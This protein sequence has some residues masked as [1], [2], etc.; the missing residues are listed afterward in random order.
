VLFYPEKL[1]ADYKFTFENDFE[2]Y[3]IAVDSKTRISAL[4]FRAEISKG[5]VFYLHGNAG[6][7][8]SWGKLAEVYL[9][10]NYD[11]CVMDYR[12]FGKS[13]GEIENEKQLHNDVGI[14]YDTISSKYT[15]QNIVIIGY[16]IGTCPAARLASVNNP[17]LL[18]LQAP[19][20]SIPD[21]V[22]HMFWVVPP[23]LVKY[24]LRTYEYV[25]N[26]KCPLIIFHGDED[27]VIYYKS[28]IKLQKHFKPS[29][30]LI[31]LEGQGHNGI[32]YNSKFQE[33]LKNLLK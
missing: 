18:I 16:S 19:Y 17:K 20:Y 28:S 23:F 24:K 2:E 11:F 3:F 26:V 5:L 14:V 21:L 9:K 31:K 30:R 4:L 29:D 6:S 32:N 13:E 27:D 22:T 15:E 1:P 8:K 33:E 10:Y 7:L 25:E 12:G